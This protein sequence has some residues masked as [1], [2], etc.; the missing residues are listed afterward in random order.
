MSHASLANS[1]AE[2]FLNCV[3]LTPLKMPLRAFQ[4]LH[5]CLF[6]STVQSSSLLGTSFPDSSFLVGGG[7]GLANQDCFLGEFIHGLDECTHASFPV[8]IAGSV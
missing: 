8:P 5:N 1:M 7:G 3:G 6:S 4:L 2:M